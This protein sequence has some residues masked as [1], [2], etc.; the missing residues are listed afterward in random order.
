MDHC[1]QPPTDFLQE[2]GVVVVHDGIC[3]ARLQQGQ[4][5]VLGVHWPPSVPVQPRQRRHRV[6]VRG[7][8]A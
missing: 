8:V 7:V 2:G 3:G 6:P 1:L 5:E 4:V